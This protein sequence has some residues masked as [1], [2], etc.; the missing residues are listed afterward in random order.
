[1]GTLKTTYKAEHGTELAADIQAKFA[2]TELA[3]ALYLLNGHATET[4]TKTTANLDDKGTE[5]TSAVPGGEVRARTGAKYSPSA[6]G[7]QRVGGFSLE[8]EGALANET[9]W[10]QFIW[11]EIIVTKADGTE[12][13]LNDSI[14]TTG[15]TYNLTADPAKPSYN[16]DSANAS[17]PFYEGSFYA[18]RTADSTTI[19]DRPSSAD[20]FV[21]REF[22]KGAKKVVS[23]AHF[24]SYMVRDYLPVHQYSISVEWTYPNKTVPANVQTLKNDQPVN[25]LP[26]GQKATLVKQYPDYSYIM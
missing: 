24:D 12:T 5:D 8:Y 20:S 19:F 2:G 14:T 17:T 4:G 3:Y 9:H 15:G 11:R 18:N 7:A 22:G 6:G 13:R 16:T 23:R 1:M 25:G 10:L 21:Q 26:A